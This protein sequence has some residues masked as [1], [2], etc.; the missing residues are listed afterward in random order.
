MGIGQITRQI[1]NL[2]VSNT[3]QTIDLGGALTIL[4]VLAGNVWI[5]ATGAVA[6]ADG[7]DCTKR[8][9]G[10]YIEL[11]NPYLSIIS[12]A[13]GATVQLLQYGDQV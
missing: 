12:D 3:A 9:A 8:S 2:A 11:R 7:T 1:G 10:S 5:Q 13:T 6:T 4:E